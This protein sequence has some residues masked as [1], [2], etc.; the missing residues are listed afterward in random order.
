MTNENIRDMSYDLYG[1]I[2]R[3]G[4]SVTEG[5]YKAYIK[6]HNDTWYC[7]NDDEV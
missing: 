4:K 2:V 7:C 6:T 5:H 1:V 3:V